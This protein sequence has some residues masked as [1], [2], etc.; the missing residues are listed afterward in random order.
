MRG[1]SQYYREPAGY[2]CADE[3]EQYQYRHYGERYG[4]HERQ[5]PLTG[6]LLAVITVHLAGSW[7]PSLARAGEG[8]V[9][10]AR[11]RPG[12]ARHLPPITVS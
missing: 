6:L 11:Q 4:Y 12:P 3:D 5:A 9:P 7:T 2:R 1:Q 10:A 8:P